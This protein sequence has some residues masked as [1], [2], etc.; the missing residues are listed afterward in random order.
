MFHRL[1]FEKT[2]K[3][4]PVLPPALA[5]PRHILV[6]LELCSVPPEQLDRMA[7][8]GA[9]CALHII[10]SPTTPEVTVESSTQLMASASLRIPGAILDQGGM[11]AGE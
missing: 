5:A 11:G 6:P 4:N 7:A 9:I 10:S 3:Y 1:F 8:A 2:L